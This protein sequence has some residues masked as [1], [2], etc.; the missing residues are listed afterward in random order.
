[1]RQLASLNGLEDANVV[2]GED[3]TIIADPDDD[4]MGVLVLELDRDISGHLMIVLGEDCALTGDRVGGFVED[5]D[6]EDLVL[7]VVLHFTD[8]YDATIA[9]CKL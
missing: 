7:I 9:S 4:L 2:P 1:L 8:H 6:I 5:V 3:L